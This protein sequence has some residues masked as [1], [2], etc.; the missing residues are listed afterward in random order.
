LR[1]LARVDDAYPQRSVLVTVREID[2]LPELRG[3]VREPVSGPGRVGPGGEDGLVGG[4]HDDHERGEEITMNSWSRDPA[5]TV[6]C[7][8][9]TPHAAPA[10]GPPVGK[11]EAMAKIPE[12]TKSSLQQ[13]LAARARER[14][15]QIS[16]INT[17]Y[18]AGFA[19]V[20]AVLPGGDSY[21]CAGCATPA[22]PTSGASRSTAPATTT[23]RTRSYPPGSM[24]GTA[25]YAL[26]T[27]CGLYLA[28]PTA[29]T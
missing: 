11:D 20:D 26:D 5:A 28:D 8:A 12:S 24:G 17:R 4:G 21:R 1:R 9:V 19:Y 16:R 29:W 15:P 18:R 13:R 3:V 10:A 23:T 7:H 14:W 6:C 2:V 27:A 22:T 25:E